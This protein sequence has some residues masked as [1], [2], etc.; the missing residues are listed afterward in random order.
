[1]EFQWEEYPLAIKEEILADLNG[2]D[3]LVASLI[4]CP[5]ELGEFAIDSFPGFRLIEILHPGRSLNC[6]YLA[7]TDPS[8]TPIQER[9]TVCIKTSDFCSNSARFS[10]A[11]WADCSEAIYRE[12]TVLRH[13]AKTTGLVGILPKVLHH[14]SVKI[15]PISV[16]YLVTE[17]MAGVQ[18]ARPEDLASI[19]NI[20]GLL[21]L[22]GKIHR[23]GVI[24][25]DLTM[26]NLLVEIPMDKSS[27]N[28]HFA[29]KTTVGWRVIDFGS[30]MFRPKWGLGQEAKR[31]NFVH[32]LAGSLDEIRYACR[33]DASYDVACL[34]MTIQEATQ[35][36]FGKESGLDIA[37]LQAFWGQLT[38]PRP[39]FRPSDAENFRRS[40]EAI[41]DGEHIKTSANISRKIR[42]SIR[43]NPKLVALGAGASAVLLF[44]GS[45]AFYQ[46]ELNQQTGRLNTELSTTVDSLLKSNSSML[47]QMTD[48]A[49]MER[50][51]PSQTRKQ[52][53]SLISGSLRTLANTKLNQTTRIAALRLLLDIADSVLEVEKVEATSE[54][55]NRT[56]QAVFELK[57][58]AIGKQL[59]VEL[60][61]IQAKSKQ[62]QIAM[63]YKRALP[64]G[65]T[66]EAFAK[67]LISKFLSLD[68]ESTGPRIAIR[69]DGLRCAM[70]LLK[71][72]LYPFRGNAWVLSGHPTLVERVY[73]HAMQGIDE[74]SIELILPLASLETEFG[75]LIHKG[76]LGKGEQRT[77]IESDSIQFDRVRKLYYAAQTRV[78]GLPLE[79]VPF[80]DMVM[81]RDLRSRIPNLLGMSLMQSGNFVESREQLQAAW[82]ESKKELEEASRSMLWLKRNVHTA[83]D[84][85]D[86][87]VKEALQIAPMDDPDHLDL[88]R[89]SIPYRRDAYILSQR[90]LQLDNTNESQTALLVNGLRWFLCELTLDNLDEGLRI[91][92]QTDHILGLR[93]PPF[94]HDVGQ[95]FLLAAAFLHVRSPDNERYREMLDSQIHSVREWLLTQISLELEKSSS[96]PFQKQ[97]ALQLDSMMDRKVFNALHQ[98]S[99]WQ[100]LRELLQRVASR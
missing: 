46:R 2:H 62:L 61:E 75:Y 65:E 51:G 49:A 53:N 21:L 20:S 64:T 74:N 50:I 56:I 86:S 96:D 3:A 45:Y 10:V 68:L 76:F 34:A 69:R 98:D 85:A 28:P 15:G 42:S 30:A 77:S 41:V 63:D 4:D 82:S 59:E 66:H 11:E 84:L 90:W 83:W 47:R 25:G 93:Q 19:G 40:L 78:N 44:A 43:R 87:H 88:L 72:A 35:L 81:Y 39:E 89:A 13:L 7:I 32:R 14:G 6:V 60:L 48:L 33:P 36:Q 37:K 16:P 79:L 12:A 73:Q 9:R 71:N 55:L 26:E 95:V 52:I 80:E 99:S 58:Q 29:R 22:L 8:K 97:F 27:M 70:N 5:I 24:H 100:S 92:E 38:E 91:L 54:C 94:G 17:Y 23:A 31:P 57:G 1:M 67:S 18:R